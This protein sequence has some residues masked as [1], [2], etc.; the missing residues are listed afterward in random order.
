MGL[1][2]ELI[3]PR[4]HI[5]AMNTTQSEMK[6]DR[7][8]N[9]SPMKKIVSGTLGGLL[10]FVFFASADD[11]HNA[12]QQGDLQRVRELLEANPELVNRKDSSFGRTPLH[13]AARGVH[14]DVLSFLLEKGADPNAVDNSKI[15]A[16]HSVS[17]RGHKEAVEWLLTNGAHVNAVDEFWK[18]PLAYAISG[19][20]EELIGLLVAKGGTLPLQGEA[21]RRLLHD[22]ASQGNRAL[23]EWMVAKGADLSSENGNGGTLL[24]SCS[25]GGLTEF[26][27]RLLNKGLAV[28]AQDRYG[29]FPLHYAARN[30]HEDVAEVL[31]QNKAD[32]DAANLAGDRPVHLARQ[33]GK[34]DLAEMLIARGAD[35]GPPRFPLLQGEYLGQK[36]PGA[37][38]ELFALGIVSTVDHE[39]SSPVFSPDG[40]EVF[41]TSI[42]DGMKIFRMRRE[43]GRWSAPE[44]APF[45]GFDDCYPRFSPDGQ[46]LYFVSWRAVKEG[47]KNAGLGINLWCVERTESGWSEPRPLGPPFD[48]GHIFGFSM[49]EE[50]TIYYTDAESGFDIYRSRLVDGR[51]TE[52]EKLD[53][54]VNSDDMEDEPFIASDESYLIFKSM[55]PGGFGGADLYISFRKK[56]GS[57]TGAK[58]LGAKVNT[59]HAERFPSV[60]RDG[61][62]FFFGSD[63]D[64]NRGDIYWVEARAI[65]AIKPKELK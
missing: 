38:P 42:S 25:E 16:L 44:L 53:E 64:G 4:S 12:A 22:S 54:A 40:R 19:N 13:W 57:W 5:E 20:H 52:P 31:L 50:G 7:S 58:N 10:F 35:P 2:Q 23:V 14:L 27:G 21:G 56:D 34:K 63:R 6:A 36:K 11:I 59:E 46:R 18:T 30:G 37:K 47:E 43:D 29:F 1:R 8:N 62:Y 28:N 32:I 24:H 51:Y 61:K 33:A 39:H 60:T 15:T 48:T 26:V 45:S 3:T 41:W 49:T 17:S 55:R 9:P 65:V